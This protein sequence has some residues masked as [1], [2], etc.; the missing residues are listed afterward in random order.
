LPAFLS[1]LDIVLLALF[2]AAAKKD[3]DF[4]T[5]LAKINAVAG[6]EINP[7]LEYPLPAPLMFEEFPNAS[8]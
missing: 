8:L 4:F 3:D 6:A 2:G 7:I 5:V 1:Q